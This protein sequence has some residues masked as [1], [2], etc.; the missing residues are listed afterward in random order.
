MIGYLD[1]R[2]ETGRRGVR[3]IAREERSEQAPPGWRAPAAVEWLEPDDDSQFQAVLADF[4]RGAG[5][6]RRLGY[7]LC[8]CLWVY[9]PIH[10]DV[11]LILI[12][13]SASILEPVEE[14]ESAIRDQVAEL[15]RLSR[16]GIIVILAL[17]IL[18]AFAFARSVTKPLLIL[19]EGARRLTEGDF[20]A[21]VDIRARDEFG[22]MGKIFNR[23]GPRL[24]EHYQ[25]RRA[26]DLAKEVQQNLLPKQ[27]PCIPGLDIAGRSLYSEDIG[28]DY[29]DYIALDAAGEEKMGVAVADVSGHGLSSALLMTSIRTLLRYR[30]LS[31][32]GPRGVVADGPGGAD[33]GDPASSLPFMP[34]STC[35]AALRWVRAGHDPAV[36]YDTHAD[37]FD[38]LWGRGGALGISRETDYEERHRPLLSG[39]VIA[40]GTDGIWETRNAAGRMFGKEN[41]RQIIRAN[42]G[43]GAR[44]IIDAVFQGLDD[45][46][47]GAGK[48][49][50]DITL[51]VMKVV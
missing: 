27:D 34:K 6:T 22:E 44:E 33:N 30:A 17:T 18:V 8:D 47:R 43:R 21:R 20:N 39:Q 38:E 42:S 50:D 49:D 23:V 9:R 10:R 29:F 24:E 46:R 35:P 41:L 16:Q 13:P 40:I 25:I 28:G 31:P 12:M 7:R 48:P 14:A 32:G 51:V 11:F 26:M 4:D 36:C 1:T 2:S 5:G 15:L 19:T 3:I 45:Y 37:R